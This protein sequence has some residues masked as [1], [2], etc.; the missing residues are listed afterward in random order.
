M[1]MDM[2]HARDKFTVE[3]VVGIGQDLMQL[4]IL[5]TGQE[6]WDQAGVLGVSQAGGNYQTQSRED[7]F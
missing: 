4:I 3:I 1:G 5:F 6:N 2:L 7:Y